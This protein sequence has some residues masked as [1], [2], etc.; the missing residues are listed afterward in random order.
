MIC[1]AG[2]EGD[3]ICFLQAG[4]P[5]DQAAANAYCY[6]GVCV[7]DENGAGRCGI[8]EGG[9]C[10]PQNNLCAGDQECAELQGGG[11]ACYP[12]VFLRG[13][14]FDAESQGAIEGAT[15]RCS[16]AAWCSTPRVR[17]PSKAPT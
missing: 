7:A 5:C 2:P 8:A 1:A 14:V 13:M 11:H 12:P 16:C 4:Q 15:R 9:A 10:D 3:A 6:E 17:V